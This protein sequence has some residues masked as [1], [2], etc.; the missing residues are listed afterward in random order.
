M[1]QNIYD[2]EA[3]FAG[4]AALPRSKKGFD[5][6]PE[7]P[8]LRALLPELKGVDVLDLGCGYGWFCRFAA[9]AGANHVTGIELS[10]RMLD[11]ARADTA[12]V[13]VTYERGDMEG[14][15]LPDA[16]FGVVYSSLAFHYVENF[17]GLIE[18]IARALKPGGRLVFSME[19]PL[20]TAPSRPGWHEIDGRKIWPLDDYLKEGPRVTEWLGARVVKQHRTLATVANT[21]VSA[22]LAIRH[23]E[24]WGPSDEQVAAWPELADE[25]LRPTFLLGAAEKT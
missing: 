24:E 18:T 13:N 4:Y 10:E 25:R 6:A 8:S 2:D 19:H 21:L 23:L 1:S 20:F 17:Y 16:A 3:F 5:G 22:G 9:E 12:S 11:K 7:W 14:L 15:A